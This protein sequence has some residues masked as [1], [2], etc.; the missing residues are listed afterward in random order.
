MKRASGLTT[1]DPAKCNRFSEGCARGRARMHPWNGVCSE[2]GLAAQY[3]ST[4]Y[5]LVPSSDERLPEGGLLY[6]ESRVP[7][8]NHIPYKNGRT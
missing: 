4:F 6:P 2:S 8:K 3:R 5:H 1:S 7:Q